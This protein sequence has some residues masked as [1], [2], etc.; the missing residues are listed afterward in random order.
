MDFRDC[1][2][3]KQDVANQQINSRHTVS[4]IKAPYFNEAGYVRALADL[5]LKTGAYPQAVISFKANRELF[6]LEAGDRF[7]MNYAD[8][9]VGKIFRITSIGE[10]APTSEEI[11]INAIEDIHHLGENSVLTVTSE[12]QSRSAA[13][14]YPPPPPEAE[15]GE[16]AETQAQTY[17][18]KLTHVKAVELPYGLTGSE[19][20]YFAV[21]AARRSGVELGYSVYGSVDAA[22][23]ALIQAATKFCYHGSLVAAY[24]EDTYDVDDAVG[25]SFDSY[26]QD[27]D[28]LETTIR[29]NAFTNLHLALIDN[30]LIAFQTITPDGTNEHRYA[31]ANVVRGLYGTTRAAHATGAD[32]YI[33]GISGTESLLNDQILP[34]TTR[35]FK[36]NPFNKYISGDLTACDVQTLAL[37]GLAATPYPPANVRVN[38]GRY[39]PTYATSGDAVIAWT[40]RYRGAGAGIGSADAAISMATPT[41]EDQFLVEIFDPADLVTAKRSTQVDALTWTYANAMMVTD[42]SGEPTSFVVQVSGIDL[43]ET[44]VRYK[45]AVISLTVRL[46]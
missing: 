13:P 46:T 5:R 36:A 27:L 7:I 32:I 25:F 15:P 30:E 11:T 10:E 40:P 39:R 4:T 26:N 14:W 37:T 23:Y 34:G 44:T 21:L 16:I 43:V 18:Y 1:I 8:E 35:Y 31:I 6:Q 20:P 38:T 24:P 45:S 12:T 29:A 3:G 9:I 22:S 19:S 17:L 42:F 33:I 41:H 2:I 28:A